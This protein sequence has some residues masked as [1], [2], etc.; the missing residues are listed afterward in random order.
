M[1]YL[2]KIK[3]TSISKKEISEFIKKQDKLFSPILSSK[4]NIDEYIE[5]AFIKGNV[6]STNDLTG[7]TTGV[8]VFYSNNYKR[9][10]GY[11]SCLVV[12]PSYQGRG[13]SKYLIEAAIKEC[14]IKDMIQVDVHTWLENERAINLYKKYGFEEEERVKDILGLDMKRLKLTKFF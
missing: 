6:Y 5:K 4:I 1:K 7:K 13:L 10:I 8:I 3:D 12:D 2:K 11:I 9:K 14:E